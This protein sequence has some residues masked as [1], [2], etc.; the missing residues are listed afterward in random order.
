MQ[1]RTERGGPSGKGRGVVEALVLWGLGYAALLVLTRSLLLAMDYDYGL[2]PVML[3]AAAQCGAAAALAFR[4]RRAGIGL[5]FLVA[6]L[7]LGS[8]RPE[9][10]ALLARWVTWAEGGLAALAEWARGTPPTLTADLAWAGAILAPLAVAT[11]VLGFCARG[12]DPFW[13]VVAGALIPILEWFSFFDPGL[14]FLAAYLV[15]GGAWLAAW[16]A[17]AGGAK[18][19]GAPAAW[20]APVG[21]AGVPGTAASGVGP[22][23][24]PY[25][26]S[27]RLTAFR[28]A[29]WVALLTAVVLVPARGLPPYPSVSPGRVA[30]WLV[31]TIPG[32][33]RLRGG[34]SAQTVGFNPDARHLGGPVVPGSGVA[35]RVRITRA[36]VRP[37]P[38]RPQAPQRLYLRGTVRDRYTGRG[39]ES[40]PGRFTFPQEAGATRWLMRLGEGRHTCWLD[41][42]LEVRPRDLPY[43]YLFA[44]WIPVEVEQ[45]GTTLS[46]VD[47]EIAADRRPREY[48][49]RARVPLRAPSELN[50]FLPLDLH[51]WAPYLELPPDLPPEV[52]QEAR[53]VTAG[54]QTPYE[55]ACRVEEYLRTTYPYDPNVRC[56]SPREDFVADFLFD[57]RRGY[58]VHHSTAMA[59]M[60]RTL[61]IPTRWVQ[62]FVVDLRT[63]TWMDVPQPSAHAWVE[64]LIPGCGWV[65]FDPTPRYPV[66]EREFTAAP[67]P[68][69]GVVS[70][71]PPAGRTGPYPG[72]LQPQPEPDKPGGEGGYL[73]PQR[74]RGFPW[75][76]PAAIL[77]T[78]GAAVPGGRCLYRLAWLRRSRRPRA[79]ESLAAFVLRQYWLTEHLLA[80]A[81]LARPPWLTPR[82]FL[83]A[84]DTPPAGLPHPREEV[85]RALATGAGEEVRRALAALTA[86]VEEAAFSPRAG[87]VPAAASAARDAQVVATWVRR[88]LGPWRWLRWLALGPP[89]PPS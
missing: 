79:G 83:R 89:L 40:R 46:T 38:V 14:D 39:W 11:L 27:E 25:G 44:P 22:A 60:L 69:G 28:A 59:V 57:L 75:Q 26:L 58:C 62:G 80:L 18:V 66:P 36:E 4:T 41:V 12:R 9:V 50:L 82:E 55:R 87:T 23:D 2:V 34:A 6:L 54:A 30:D 88:C 61:A 77:V 8:T 35:M 33:G 29:L 37:G 17:E 78:V 21:A 32:L 5:G 56:P 84:F 53:R 63:G 71:V 73:P 7:T 1:R 72:R 74:G 45:E 70:S 49:V 48:T 19:P 86:S 43:L 76:I 31:E 42:E 15:L 47:C 24:T 10:R 51:R 68:E 64:V 20:R 85:R 13:P 52:E 67:R 65:T 81:G 3:A 16:R